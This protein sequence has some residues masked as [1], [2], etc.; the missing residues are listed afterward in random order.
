MYYGWIILNEDEKAN[1]VKLVATHAERFHVPGEPLGATTSMEHRIFTADDRPT[2]TKQYRYPRI[3][4]EEINQQVNKLLE[5][6]II[7]PSI[8]P[9]NS[10]LWIVPKK[11]DSAGNKRWRMVIDYR[12]LNE[13]TTGDAYPLPNITDILDQLGNAKFFRY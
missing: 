5:S 11:P 9:Y 1:I 7:E 2:N 12:N 10:P 8:S 4:R 6:E 3:R 13:K